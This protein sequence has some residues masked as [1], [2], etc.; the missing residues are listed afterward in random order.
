MSARRLLDAL[1]SGLGLIAV[2][3]LLAV[4]AVGI[5]LAGPGSILYRAQRLGLHRRPFTLYKLRTMRVGQPYS[6]AITAKGD[7]RVFPFGAWLRRAKLDELPQLFN[8]VRGDMAIV[9]P[10]PEDPRM[11]ERFYAPLHDETFLV[12]PGL[13]S[14]GSI[15]AYTHGEAQLDASDPERCYAERL[16][17]LKLALDLVYVRRASLRYDLALMGRTVWVL[18]SALLGRRHFPLPPELSEARRIMREEGALRVTA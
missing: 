16:L 18:G 4:A 14:P 10:R 13:T 3:P 9:G 12:L 1:L 5:R 2:V 7:P 17:P 8:I 11:V 15:Y 6:S